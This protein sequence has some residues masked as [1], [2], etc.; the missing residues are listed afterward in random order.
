M[1]I[2]FC[3]AKS[4]HDL[5]TFFFL[6]K[7]FL[8]APIRRHTKKVM[9]HGF[10]LTFGVARTL[11]PAAYRVLPRKF[12]AR[13]FIPLQ[14]HRGSRVWF[15]SHATGLHFGECFEDTEHCFE[16]FLTNSSKTR[17]SRGPKQKNRMRNRPRLKCTP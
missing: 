7:T 17:M 15:E 11:Q 14:F 9:D 10:P 13:N 8:S 16:T 4:Q 2:S 1:T 6:Q 12:W 5:G 3:Q